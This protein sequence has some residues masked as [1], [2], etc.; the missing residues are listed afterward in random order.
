MHVPH[1]H[2]AVILG[3][4]FYAVISVAVP[5]PWPVDVVSEA[6]GIAKVDA[7]A[8]QGHAAKRRG[9][10]DNIG[11][12]L[13][14]GGSAGHSIKGSDSVSG[15]GGKVTFDVKGNVE[16]GVFGGFK[17][18]DLNVGGGDKVNKKNA[19]KALLKL[20]NEGSNTQNKKSGT[21]KKGSKKPN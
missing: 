3:I 5:V 8:Q 18:G 12:V 10:D 17:Q 1:L 2:Q 19:N 11:D 21:S 20:S 6:V 13:K 7:E 9:I 14:R 15:N 4:V 16:G